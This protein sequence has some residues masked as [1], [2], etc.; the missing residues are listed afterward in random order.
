MIKPLQPCGCGRPISSHK[1][2]ECYRT[3]GLGTK[4]TYHQ[5]VTTNLVRVRRQL[6]IEGQREIMG[7][8]RK[9][10]DKILDRL[11][12]TALSRASRQGAIIHSQ[13][14][15]ITLNLGAHERIWAQA[16]QEVLG[17][18]ADIE[19]INDYT[20]IVQSVAARSYSRTC[21]IVGEEQAHDAPIL[22]LRRAQQ[23]AQQVTRVNDTT[24]QQ[25]STA[26]GTAIDEGLTVVEV[27]NRLREDF[28]DIAASRMPTIA[29]TEVSR[30]IDEG[31]KQ[32]IKE[33]SV[34][35]TVMVIGCTAIEPNGPLFDGK[36][37]CNITGVPAH[38]VDELVFHPNHTGA[39]V[40][41]SFFD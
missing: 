7:I 24:R 32:S 26:I 3:K 22:I 10:F 38:R 13:K 14:A 5:R 9:F 4:S 12:N 39:L 30:A 8:C 37:T 16:L 17:P 31:V 1:L 20:P 15:S 33:S 27:A 25:L 36:P 21:A 40:P 34:V 19:L 29:R 2:F 41:E 11:V 23:M 18:S 35:K 28:P 6:M